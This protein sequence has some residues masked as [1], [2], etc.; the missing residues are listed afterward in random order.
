MLAPRATNRA[1]LAALIHGDT[2]AFFS[3]RSASQTHRRNLA[4]GDQGTF[5]YGGQRLALQWFFRAPT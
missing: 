2:W 4:S 1:L 3:Q 5:R